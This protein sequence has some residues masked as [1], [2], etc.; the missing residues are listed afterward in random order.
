M[1]VI[2]FK[3]AIEKR[4]GS[5]TAGAI[6]SAVLIPLLVILIAICIIVWLRKRQEKGMDFVG[7]EMACNSFDSGNRSNPQRL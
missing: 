2:L 4:H 7:R 5:L 3:F 1:T 6:V